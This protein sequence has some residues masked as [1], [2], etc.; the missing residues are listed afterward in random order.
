[1]RTAATEMYQIQ[2]SEKP[3]VCESSST[4]TAMM[5]TRVAEVISD[6]MVLP[7]AWNMLELTKMIPDATKF[8]ARMCRYST[9]TAIAAG[10]LVKM[11]TMVSALNQA[12]IASAS[13]P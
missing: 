11:A 2:R 9:A 7:I 4:G 5:T 6:G 3:A 1:M 12:T 8:H 13:M 10:S